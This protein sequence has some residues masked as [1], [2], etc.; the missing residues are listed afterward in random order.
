VGVAAGLHPEAGAWRVG[1]VGSHDC[2]G[3]AIEGESRL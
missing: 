1:Q 2:G 3:A